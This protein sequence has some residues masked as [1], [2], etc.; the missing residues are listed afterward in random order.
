MA[1]RKAYESVVR[2]QSAQQTKLLIARAA[3]RLFLSQGYAESSVAAIAREAGVSGQTV[4]NV[5]GTKAAL[6][7]YLYDVTLV[8]DAE[9]VPFA[10]RPDVV[11]LYALP[12]AREFLTAYARIGLGLLHRLGPLMSVVMAGAAAGNA[13]LV[14][15]VE[16]TGRERLV[17]ATMAAQHAVKLG[18]LRDGVTTD[19][20]RDAIWTLNSVEVWRLLCRD[21]GWS[22]EAY[23]SW[24][25]RAMADAFLPSTGRP[26]PPRSSELS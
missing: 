22:D 7:K 12:D 17:G 20:A 8:G 18:G 5:F 25:G 16:Q 3:E 1:H 26:G 4:Y 13:D 9:P 2:Q 23:V 24:V 6:L 21:R 11:A 15:L 10:Q 14:A 19:D